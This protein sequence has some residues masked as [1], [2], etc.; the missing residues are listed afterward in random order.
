[1]QAQEVGVGLVEAVAWACGGRRRGRCR[2]RVLGDE[3]LQLVLLGQ[4]LDLVGAEGAQARRLLEPLEVLEVMRVVL[5]GVE[6]GRLVLE[7]LVRLDGGRRL[8]VVVVVAEVVVVVVVV[9]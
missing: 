5:V 1:M 3:L 8:Q 9:V 2:C 4:L 6:S 7:V